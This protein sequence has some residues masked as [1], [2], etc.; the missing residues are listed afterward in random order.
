M[1]LVWG[2]EY[3]SEH[4]SNV[5]AEDY[6]VCSKRHDNVNNVLLKRWPCVKAIVQT[7]A[8]GACTATVKYGA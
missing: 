2:D 8:I 6:R 1:S 5:S 7:D 4:H 3:V